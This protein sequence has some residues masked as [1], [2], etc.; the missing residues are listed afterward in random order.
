[1]RQIQQ[2]LQQSIEK[3]QMPP[4]CENCGVIETP[5][6]RKAYGK[7]FTEGFKDVQLSEEDGGAIAYDN[8]ETDAAGN[9]TRYRLIKKSLAKGEDKEKDG[10]SVI[11]LCNRKW[12]LITF[13]AFHLLIFS[14]L[15]SILLQMEDNAP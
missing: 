11:V 6:W 1:M 4:Y 7:Y 15:R 10:W 8:I 3:G 12:T 13:P 14:S 2:R 5:T 9:V